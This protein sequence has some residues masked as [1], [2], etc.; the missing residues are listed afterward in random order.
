MSRLVAQDPPKFIK[1]MKL[2]VVDFSLQFLKC[3]SPNMKNNMANTI[4][5]SATIDFVVVV[6]VVVFFFFETEL[7]CETVPTF[8]GTHSVDLAGLKL[9]NICLPLPPKCWD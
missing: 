1:I 6:V 2:S 8:P 4:I 3:L 9:T 5:S 7:F